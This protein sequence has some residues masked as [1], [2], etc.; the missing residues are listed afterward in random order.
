MI[1]TSA[2]FAA[3]LRAAERVSGWSIPVL[4][5]GET[6]TGKELMARHIHKLSGRTGDFVALNC[7]ALPESLA[8]S[9]LFGYERG[10]FTG[11]LVGREGVWHSASG[12]TLF[13][14]EVG[15]LPLSI[16]AK[17]LRVVE[18]GQLVRVGGRKP[19]SVNV[20]V[21]AATHRPLEQWVEQG[22]FRRDLYERLA[23]YELHIPPLRDRADDVV[24]LARHILAHHPAL[25]PLSMRLTAEAAAHMMK[26]EWRGN[27]R[28]L[29]RLLLRLA[30]DG[31]SEVR[32]EHLTGQA[33]PTV[34]PSAT[35]DGSAA[36]LQHLI[37]AALTRQEVIRR[38][39][40]EAAL[41]V[42]T[43]TLQRI[44]SELQAQG[45]IRQ[46]GHARNI[47]YRLS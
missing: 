26:L 40:L 18:E 6:G 7:A 11:A 39:E 32:A 41:S 44:L 38:R 43:R 36:T 19:E 37:I 25:Q 17:L 15:E 2:A 3:C 30:V 31:I 16:Q 34:S 27:V 42:P 13:L 8:E 4:I 22:L 35:T 28:E 24:L 33:R 23:R 20:R 14:D 29:E 45:V 1:G 46:S 5:E 9:E 21:L 12:G 10:A 47:T